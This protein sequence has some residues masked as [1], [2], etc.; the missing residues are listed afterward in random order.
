MAKRILIINGHPDPRP[1]RYC[2]AIAEACAEGARAAGHSVETIAIAAFEFAPLQYWEDWKT[3]EAPPPLKAAQE[4]IG[5]ADHIIFIYP[6]WLGC[7]PA[8]TK[9]FLE[10][11]LRP[12]FAVPYDY[13]EKLFPGLLK[14]KSARII[15]TMGMPAF[16]YR[17][18]FFAHSNKLLRRNIL[19]FCGISPVRETVI[20]NI[21]GMDDAARRAW[22]ERV[23]GL[24]AKAA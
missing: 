14:G 1:E 21:M 6:L 7:M 22:L 10:Q 4:K 24:A 2:V 17:W 19:N 8:L 12:G 9:A 23:A 20:G 3:G 16:I 13:A 18:Y 11:T 5:W 15:V